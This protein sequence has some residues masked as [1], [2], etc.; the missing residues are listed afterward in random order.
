MKAHTYPAA[1]VKGGRSSGGTRYY[2]GKN[3]GAD[4]IVRGLGLKKKRSP[5]DDIIN[6]IIKYHFLV[7]QEIQRAREI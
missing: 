1:R 4:I 2:A 5:I 6:N 3:R 7:E